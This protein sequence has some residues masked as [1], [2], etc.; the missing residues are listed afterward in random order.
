MITT[1]GNFISSLR[2]TTPEG[3]M[4]VVTAFRRL[5]QHD[6][7]YKEAD[8]AGKTVVLP[9]HVPGPLLDSPEPG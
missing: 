2:I 3:F 1:D 9:T 7:S 5:V 6:C 8:V 4:A